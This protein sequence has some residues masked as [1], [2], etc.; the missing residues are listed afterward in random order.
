MI[1]GAI[2]GPPHAG[3]PALV[4]GGCAAGHIFDRPVLPHRGEM[5]APVDIKIMNSYRAMGQQRVPK[6]IGSKE[7]PSNTCGPLAI[8]FDTFGYFWDPLPFDGLQC[9]LKNKHSL[10]K[11]SFPLASRYW[12]EENKT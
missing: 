9:M 2:G 10:A 11:Q 8:F 12:P 4:A 3:A 5:E 7:K 6:H 1:S